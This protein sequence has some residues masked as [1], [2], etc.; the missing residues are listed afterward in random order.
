MELKNIT[1]PNLTSTCKLNIIKRKKNI[2]LSSLLI[3][4]VNFLKLFQFKLRSI[5]LTTTNTIFSNSDSTYVA[6][7]L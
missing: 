4:L 7:K 6:I 3:Y 5:M 2:Y 1:Q